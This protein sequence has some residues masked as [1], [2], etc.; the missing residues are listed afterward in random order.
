MAGSLIEGVPTMMDMYSGV[1]D[2]TGIDTIVYLDD[3]ASM[4]GSN[5]VEGQ[6]AL[7][8][9]EKRLKT[10]SNNGSDERFLPTRIV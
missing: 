10:N 6:K 5:L 2:V 9:L 1:L 7:Q 8:S 4:Q 3:S